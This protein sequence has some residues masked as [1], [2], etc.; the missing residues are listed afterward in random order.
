MTIQLT[1][2][3]TLLAIA[4]AKQTNS[5]ASQ[6][7]SLLAPVPNAIGLLPPGVFPA[8]R[9]AIFAL[10]VANVNLL[11]NHYTIVGVGIRIERQRQ[12]ARTIG[13]PSINT[14]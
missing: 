2:H 13:V 7:A 1:D 12:L 8:T 14:D 6:P 9:Q 11:L 4:A 10:S 5:M 3:N